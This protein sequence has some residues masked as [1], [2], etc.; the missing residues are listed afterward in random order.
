MLQ[1]NLCT[2]TLRR[3]PR[4]ML[5]WS[6]R[7]IKATGSSFR[8]S[9]H[10]LAPS[11]LR[12]LTI[13]L[14]MIALPRM[15][16]ARD[17]SRRHPNCMIRQ[18]KWTTQRLRWSTLL[19]QTS[20]AKIKQSLGRRIWLNIRIIQS[21]RSSKRQLYQPNKES[22]ICRLWIVFNLRKRQIT[23]KFPLAVID[24]CLWLS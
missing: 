10:G 6:V 16:W 9:N 7:S 18:R 5:M 3:C 23:K 8:H 2:S 15:T 13:S 19:I 11:L 14:L 4:R 12:S 21:P 20:K 24:A 1:S 22:T 17:Q